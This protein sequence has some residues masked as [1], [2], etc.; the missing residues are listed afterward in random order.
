MA[1]IAQAGFNAAALGFPTGVADMQARDS[2]SGDADR[3]SRR[4]TGFTS[5]KLRQKL[6]NG[7]LRSS[8]QTPGRLRFSR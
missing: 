5:R 8:R 4:V 7:I 1:P 6:R 2:G 3:A